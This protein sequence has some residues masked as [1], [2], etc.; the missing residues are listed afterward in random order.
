MVGGVFYLEGDGFPV[1]GVVTG[2]AMRA[3]VR[4]RVIALA[5]YFVGELV[6][7][8]PPIDKLAQF[9]SFSAADVGAVVEDEAG[10]VVVSAEFIA[11]LP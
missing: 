6:G 2:P 1:V 9:L 4:S 7:L 8:G 3:A 11:D 10:S 5:K